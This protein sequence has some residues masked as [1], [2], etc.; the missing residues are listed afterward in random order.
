MDSL[1]TLSFKAFLWN[2]IGQFFTQIISFIVG[3]ILARILS[4]NEYGLLA[5]ALFF[6]GIS[7][8]FIDGGFSS[9]LIRKKDPSQKDLSTVFIFNIIMALFMYASIYLLS[10]SISSFFKESK[11][12]LIIR[13]LSL[14]FIIVAFGTI[15][16]VLLTK[17]LDYKTQSIIRVIS[18]II[19]GTIGVFMA[20]NGYGIWAL[21]IQII[22]QSIIWVVSIWVVCK[23]KP[24]FFFSKASFKEFFSFG[25][26]L[27]MSSFLYEF[28][29]QAYP[30]I[31]GR[32]FSITQVGYYNRAESYQK[33]TSY[34]IS[35][36]VNSVVFPS[37]SLVQDD[38]ERLREGYRKIIKLTMFITVPLMTGLILLSN[39]LIVLLITEKWLPIVPYLQWLCIV[40]MFQPLNAIILNILNVKGRSDIFL[41]LIIVNKSMMILSILIGFY[42]GIIGLIIGQVFTALLTFLISAYY[43]G[44]YIKYSV[45]AQI[46]DILPFF[47]LSFVMF[48]IGYFLGFKIENYILRISFQFI[49]CIILY[50]SFAKL[51]NLSALK[52]LINIILTLSS[53]KK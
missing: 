4:P 29:A 11:L 18:V 8:V 23:W 15:Q 28:F 7:N 36:M 31:I 37:L 16:G 33:I 43:S 9:A 50:F 48:I 20:L 10:P 51:F 44:R 24:I 35:N 13:I 30:I 27:M 21:V 26:K 34:T 42:W 17:K 3:I 1:S 5:M 25:S 52:E 47:A 41:Y 40:G 53:K 32:F 14:N 12:T 46:M 2:A 6:N 19:S 38:N 45:I 49:I 39:P 22:L